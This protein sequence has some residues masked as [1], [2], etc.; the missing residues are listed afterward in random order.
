MVNHI[1]HWTSDRVLNEPLSSLE[2]RNNNPRQTGRSLFLSFFWF[3]SRN[4]DNRYQDIQL[5]SIGLW[6]AFN[7]D[8]KSHWEARATRLNDRPVPG[9]LSV[10]PQDDLP[11]ENLQDIVLQFVKMEMNDFAKSVRNTIW[12]VLKRRLTK[13]SF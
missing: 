1:Q 9:L 11:F 8:T 6:N 10:W 7:D 13:T 3:L 12:H 5:I 2:R 4:G